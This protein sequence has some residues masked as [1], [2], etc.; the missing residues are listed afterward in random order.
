[1]K[2]KIIPVTDFMQNC[3]LIWDEK[4]LDAVIIDPGGDIEILITEIEKRAL[5]LQYTLL[6]HGHLDHVGGCAAIA[7]YFSVPIFGP[8]KEDEFLIK[9]LAAQ[10]KIFGIEKYAAFTPDRYLQEGDEIRFADIQLTVLHCPGHTPGHVVFVNHTDKLISMGD[11]LF[12][13]GIGRTDFPKSNRET[14]IHSIKTKILPLG[15]DYHFTS[16][17]G[18]MSSLANE[19]Q[20]NP[21]LQD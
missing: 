8:Q 3:T 1:M 4:H 19:R 13:G 20:Y 18:P 5:N 7:S 21:F 12:N 15:D 14:L 16:G 17:H 9:G 2:F 11:V 6:T 10:S